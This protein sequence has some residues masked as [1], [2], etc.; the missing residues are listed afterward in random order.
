MMNYKQ[1][2]LVQKQKNLILIFLKQQYKIKLFLKKIN[3]IQM[4][5][6]AKLHIIQINND[7]LI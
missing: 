7:N 6:K 2:M 3:Y 5:N 4:K 1:K